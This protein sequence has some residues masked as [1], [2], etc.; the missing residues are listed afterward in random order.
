[1]ATAEAAQR[2]DVG[3]DD[4][5]APGWKAVLRRTLKEFSN[6]N[7]TD[8]AAALTYYAVLALF[9]AMLVLV[10]LVGLFGQYPQTTDA[11]LDILRQ[12]G[13]DPD[14][15]NGAKDTINGVVQN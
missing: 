15:L 12:A 7:L 6:D 3:P 2:K 8:W 10:A 4:I 13:V 5:P 1:M 14:T 11:L 9:P